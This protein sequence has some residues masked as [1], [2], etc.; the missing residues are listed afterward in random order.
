MVEEMLNGLHA[1]GGQKFTIKRIE[2]MR[3]N[4]VIVDNKLKKSGSAPVVSG[5]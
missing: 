4:F 3:E 1:G 5:M 2:V